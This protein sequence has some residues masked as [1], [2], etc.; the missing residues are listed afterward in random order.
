LTLT[1]EISYAKVIRKLIEEKENII[2]LKTKAKEEKKK[3][4]EESYLKGFSAALHMF[5]DDQSCST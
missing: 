1:G 4:E 5:I 2:K 3:A